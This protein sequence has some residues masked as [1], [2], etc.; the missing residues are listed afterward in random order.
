[1]EYFGRG[2]DKLFDTREEADRRALELALV[3]CEE[4]VRERWENYDK[5]HPLEEYPLWIKL[6]QIKNNPNSK[7]AYSDL[8]S[9][10]YQIDD[11]YPPGI[12]EVWEIKC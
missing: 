5:Q 10:V 7:E 9:L 1:M 3:I 4:A 8:G 6:E 12:P 2:P 11:E